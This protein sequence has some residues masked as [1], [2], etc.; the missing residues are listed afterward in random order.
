MNGSTDYVAGEAIAYIEIPQP[1][2]Y[3][4][5]VNSDDGF[6]VSMGNATNTT[7]LILGAFDAGRGQADTQFYFN[8]EKAG[9]YLFRLLYFEGGSDAR[10]EWFTINS[11][12]KR[13]LVNGTQ[14]GALKAYRTR[15]VA[16]P[17]LPAQAPGD[18]SGL[19]GY[20]R[21][22][23]TAGTVVSDWSGKNHP[24]TIINDAAGSW[25]TDAER[26]AVYQATGTNVIDFGTI[27]PVMSLTNDFTWSLWLNSFETGTAAATDNNIVF[28]NRYNKSG[29]EFNPR[30]F[31]KFTPSKFEWHF[32]GA[33]QD[34]DY[35][36]FP[37]NKW[38][39]HAVVKA[40]S[41]L[42]YY[43]D[44]V[45]MVDTNTITGAP[46]NAQPLY[47]GGQGAVERG[48]GLADEVAIFDRALSA[49]EVQQVFDLGSAGQPLAPQPLALATTTIDAANLTVT[50][51]GG[52]APFKV[53]T[54]DNL[55]TGNW[56]DVGSPTNERTA[57]VP[58]Q[59]PIMFVRVVGQ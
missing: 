48:K 1:G 46:I 9:V 57:T 16:E 54:R 41:R 18:L 49:A 32:N 36:D 8:A 31:N 15:T 20:W 30:E 39:H 56:A 24:G 13:A 34:V 22:D 7:Y 38:T 40:G 35:P 55:S 25:V 47:L 45:V 37:T 51:A 21:M 59:G 5:V 10:V 12:G 27:L 23:E 50:W 29:A 19:I 43:R 44:G 14:A 6:Q 58:R 2:V 28:G 17:P 3:S 33:G 42:T 52:T 11:D 53:Q 26:G 4:M